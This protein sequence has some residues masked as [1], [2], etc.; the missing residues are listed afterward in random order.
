MR[1]CSF[2]LFVLLLA[3][4]MKSFNPVDCKRIY[5]DSNR[6]NNKGIIN[7]KVYSQF[8]KKEIENNN[9]LLIS[10]FIKEV[11][12]ASCSR[13]NKAPNADIITITYTDTIVRLFFD[14]DLFGN[15]YNGAYFKISDDL[16]DVLNQIKNN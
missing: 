14:G 3:G 15:N 9:K 11:N 2:F 7:I 13:Y 16:K 4:C 8:N 12:L 6:L 1:K 10:Q 5:Q